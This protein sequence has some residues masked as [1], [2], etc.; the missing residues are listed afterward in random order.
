MPHSHFPRKRFGQN[1]LIDPEVIAKIVRALHPKPEDNLVEIGP[2]LGALTKNVLTHVKHLNVIEIDKDLVQ[3]LKETYSPGV[4]T[5]YQANA[6]DFPFHTLFEEKQKKLRVF[7]NLPYNISTPLLFHLLI[8]ADFIQDMVFML[9]KEVVMRMAAKVHTKDY[10]RLSIMIQYACEVHGLF[11]I[12]PT[13]FSPPPK[14]TSSMVQLIPYTD[15][16]PFPLATNTKLFS[17]VVTVAFSHRRKT[18][19]NALAELISHHHLDGIYQQVGIDPMRRPETLSI[20]EFISLSNAL[21]SQ[22]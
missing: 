17:Q 1:F 16:R 21:A 4:M 6:L 14:V 13:A 8:Y 3:K 20:E 10:G 15:N 22:I 18:L 2:G 9:Q 5:V 7:G 12:A 19:K 11:D